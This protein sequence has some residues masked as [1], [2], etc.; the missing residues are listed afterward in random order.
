MD[1]K[2]RN[3]IVQRHQVG[4]SMRRIARELNVAR[5]TVRRVLGRVKSER[6]GQARVAGLTKPATRPSVLDDDDH[7]IRQLLERYPNSTAVRFH[8]ELRARGVDPSC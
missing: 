8:E 3:E 1:E 5:T 2:L 7:F 6:S 4:T